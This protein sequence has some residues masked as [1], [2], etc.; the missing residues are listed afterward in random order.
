MLPML[1]SASSE[2]KQKNYFKKLNEKK[3]STPKVT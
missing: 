2:K 1:P 3:Y